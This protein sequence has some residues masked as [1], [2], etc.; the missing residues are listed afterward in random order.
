MSVAEEFPHSLDLNRTEWAS[1]EGGEPHFELFWQDVPGVHV[2]DVML[3]KVR[4]GSGHVTA[5]LEIA[6]PTEAVVVVDV[7]GQVDVIHETLSTR[8]TLEK[9]RGTTI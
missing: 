7:V 6:L 4:N 3:A 9:H 8:P 1:E 5:R 2:T